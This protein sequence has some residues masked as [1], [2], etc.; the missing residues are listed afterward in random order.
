[1]IITII[2]LL[3]TIGYLAGFYRFF[4]QSGYKGYLALI[5]VYRAWIMLN[6]FNKR[7]WWVVFAV[8]P[9]FS[10]FL[11]AHL[12]GEISDS[13]RKYSFWEHNAAVVFGWVILPYWGWSKDVSYHGIG[14]VK[15]GDKRP[16]RSKQREWAD[17]ILFAVFAAYFIRTFFIELYTIPTSSM[18]DSLMVGDFLF[19]SKVHYGPRVPMTPIAF[20]LVHHSLP[21][22]LGGGQAYFS[23]PQLPYKRLPGFQDIKRN[24][25][26]VFNFP[27]NDT[28]TLEYGSTKTYY[29]LVRKA[30][31][32]HSN[33]T[34]NSA[35]EN[36]KMRHK[37]ISRPV[38]KRENYIKRC[39]GIAGDELQIINDRLWINGELAYEPEHIQYS[40]RI[41][42]SADYDKKNLIDANIYSLDI[43]ESSSV[44]TFNASNENI[45]DLCELMDCQ[46]NPPLRVTDIGAEKNLEKAPTSVFIYPHN[47]RYEAQFNISNYGP[48]TIPSRGM[49]VN[50]KDSLQYALY[51]RV[52]NAYEGH[53]VVREKGNVIR[54]DGEIQD[55]YTF[56]MDYY[57]MMGDN[58]HGSQ[59]S[60]FWGFVP[61]DHIVGKAWFVL[62]SLN[63]DQKWFS[64]KKVRWNRFFLPIH[65]RLTE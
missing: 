23:K 44:I 39:V 57:W 36:V 52:I 59:D 63:K 38:D 49:T 34:W 51:R 21:A 41:R 65:W 16:Q 19:V 64:G 43:T 50:L 54:I 8:L 32:N 18:E 48:I 27:A 1:M 42:R 24:D 35:R 13:Y 31:H 5:P 33:N 11:Y 4:E 30:Y 17:A 60:R 3:G 40:Y 25:L 14:G 53:T 20:P 10:L 56:T 7:K 47:E 46:S 58:R 29:E 61:E 2:L 12:I 45:N 9:G 15:E 28:L 6:H 62:F 26:V 22:I 55:E 37:I